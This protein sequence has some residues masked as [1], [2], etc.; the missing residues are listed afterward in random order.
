MG[1]YDRDYYRN[2][3]RRAPALGSVTIW[4]IVI[5]V[6]VF[7]ADGLIQRRSLTFDAGPLERWGYFSLERAVYHAQVWRF[8]TFQFLHAGAGHLALNMLALVFCGPIVEGHFGARRFLAYYLIC[9]IAGAVTYVILWAAGV[10]IS[11]PAVPLVGASA[12]AFGVMVAASQFAPDLTVPVL[13]MPFALRLRT[14]I[15]LCLI[16]AAVVIF[17][18]GFNPGGQAA[19]AGGILC[20]FLLVYNQHLLNIIVPA[21]R[22]TTMS[23]LRPRRRPNRMQKDWS[24]DLNR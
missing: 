11:S 5:N 8:V 14:I 2:D 10:L 3:A 22:E 7:V 21:R 1:I 20:G 17:R 4:L 13:Y 6:L 24:K 16:G 9:G 23:N 12:G 15:W 19:H 18:S